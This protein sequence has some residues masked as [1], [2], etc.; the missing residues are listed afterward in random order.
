MVTGKKT[1]KGSFSMIYYVKGHVTYKLETS[2]V[3]ENSSGL[4][5][6]ITVPSGSRLY[7]ASPEE[8]V[9]CYTAMIVREDDMSLYGFDDRVGLELFKKL[10]TVNGVGSKAAMAILSALS[11]EELKQAIVYEDTAM[12]TRANGIGKKTAQRIVLDLKDKIGSLA[13]GSSIATGESASSEGVDASSSN[14]AV[15]GEAI[16]ALMALGYSQPEAATAMQGI[17]EELTVEECIKYALKNL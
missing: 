16:N 8:E 15:R 12:L 3:M 6:E 9:V 5:F 7:M 14:M 4:G 11:A 2:V 13:P 17:T 1:R 10:V